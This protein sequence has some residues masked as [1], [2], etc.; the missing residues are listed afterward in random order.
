MLNRRWM[1]LMGLLML[2]GATLVHAQVETRVLEYQLNGQ[3][4][5]SVA[6]WDTG[7][8]GK[9]PVVLVIHEWWGLNDY[10]KRRINMLAEQGYLGLAVDM[11][12]QGRTTTDAKQAGAWAT[13]VRADPQAMKL[14]DAA[15]EAVAKLPEA[16]VTQRA[17][18]G[19]CFG[20]S[21]TLAYARSGADLKLAASF[22]GNLA[23]DKPAQPGAIKGHVM[24]LH[25]ADD[26]FE[27][28]TAITD[29]IAEMRHAKAD[30]QLVHYGNAVHSFTN[31]G[32]G[33]ANIPGVAYQKQADE[34]S[35]RLL[36][37]GL[38][39]VFGR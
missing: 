5:Q 3:T 28:S 15:T 39:E 17:C 34:R 4:Y 33:A 19:Y 25:G 36:L 7:I 31:P 2:T 11:Y 14:L 21:V 37:D 13:A 35:W 23:T 26:A 29:F 30:W 12:G 22:H 6:A 1:V 18:I 38:R 32:A 10:A 8:A 20:G 27:P 16:D 9:R 24:V